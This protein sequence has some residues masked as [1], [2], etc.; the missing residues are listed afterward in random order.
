MIVH[1]EIPADL[2]DA[3]QALRD[4]DEIAMLDLA[5]VMYRYI[6]SDG[7]E[8][9]NFHA[10]GDTRMTSTIGLVEVVKQ[11][12]MTPSLAAGLD[13]YEDET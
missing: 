13:E 7:E 5:V 9:W 3:I 1:D 11:R 8:G 2:A 4:D 10:R 12:M 6:D